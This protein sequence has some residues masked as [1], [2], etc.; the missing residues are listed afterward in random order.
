MH[1]LNTLFFAYLICNSSLTRGSTTRDH[2]IG[3]ITASLAN[4]D[5]AEGNRKSGAESLI[6]AH[7][8][9]AQGYEKATAAL[10]DLMGAY[11][12]VLKDTVGLDG[13]RVLEIGEKDGC[14]AGIPLSAVT[15]LKRPRS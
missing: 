8:K 10:A 5:L 4:L 6:S 7:L 12:K 2:N 1:W 15:A 13:V 11:N 3:D 9:A 14:A